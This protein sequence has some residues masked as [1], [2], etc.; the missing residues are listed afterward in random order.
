MWTILSLA[1]VVSAGIM[2][3]GICNRK[4]SKIVPFLVLELLSYVGNFNAELN[5]ILEFGSDKYVYII[6]DI[7]YLALRLYFWLLLYTFYLKL[8]ENKN[9]ENQATLDVPEKI[10][11][12]YDTNI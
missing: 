5:I 6:L 7:L 9:Q 2:L 12:G 10:V 11:V 1:V 8:L 3:Y 4:E